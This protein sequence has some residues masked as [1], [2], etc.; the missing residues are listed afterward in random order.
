MP[1]LLVRAS[2]ALQRP[3]ALRSLALPAGARRAPTVTVR[4]AGHGAAI[5]PQQ[6]PVV[7]CCGNLRVAQVGNQ[8]GKVAPTVL[9]P[10]AD[11]GAAIASGQG[12]MARHCGQLRV[13]QVGDQRGGVVPTVFVPPQ[14]TAPPP[15]LGGAVW[16]AAAATCG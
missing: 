12:R 9:V 16:P 10:A 1:S 13:D 14:A 6:G 15:L 4:A 7:P 8:R 5:A 11:H 3:L 2:S